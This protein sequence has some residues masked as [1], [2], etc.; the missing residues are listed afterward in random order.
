MAW[1][2]III[3]INDNEN[4]KWLKRNMKEMKKNNK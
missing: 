3:I 1:K 2:K 4:N